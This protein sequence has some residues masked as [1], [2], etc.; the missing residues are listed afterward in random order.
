MEKRLDRT[1]IR[2]LQSADDQEID[3]ALVYLYKASKKTVRRFILQNKGIEQDVDDVFHDGLIAF[4]NLV[5]QHKIREDTN[6]EAYLY[7]IC[8]N[9]WAKKLM[10]TP[11]SFNLDERFKT[12]P[13]EEIHIDT[14]LGEEQKELI[15]IILKELG[16]ECQKILKLFYY[17]QLKMKEIVKYLHYANDQVLRN[18]KTKC[19]KQ[20]RKIV[21]DSPFYKNYL[22]GK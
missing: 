2:Q 22:T 21:L 7:S 20:L 18:K 1:I 10:K 11:K 16:K 14:I 12:I 6:V 4:Y 17:E 3:S 19:M 15:E 9:M 8:R 13:T 5:K